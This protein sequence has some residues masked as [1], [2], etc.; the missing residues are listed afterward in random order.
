MHNA[1][2]DNK[3][4]GPQINHK[5]RHIQSGDVEGLVQ[6]NMLTEER[7]LDNIKFDFDNES[8]VISKRILVIQS[9][10]YPS[11]K[12]KDFSI[13]TAIGEIE[14]R[15]EKILDNDGRSLKADFNPMLKEM[16]NEAGSIDYSR[17]EIQEK[18]KT[19]LLLTVYR[20][21]E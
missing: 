5:G 12:M 10:S 17:S 9:A 6:R 19:L 1:T 21:E 4:H 16:F 14:K 11:Q 20:K 2:H 7:R 18:V 8:L 15:L 13:N 3:G